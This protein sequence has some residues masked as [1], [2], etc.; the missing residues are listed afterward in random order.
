MNKNSKDIG[1]AI[2]EKTKLAAFYI[3]EQTKC[4][5]T[6]ALWYCA[7]DIASFFERCHI[8][9]K[10]DLD[11]LLSINKND[12]EYKTFLRH[13]SYRLHLYTG[14]QDDCYNW[15][16]TERLLENNDWREAIIFLAGSMKSLRDGESDFSIKSPSV[17]SYYI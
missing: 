15:Y 3:W 14:I 1:D 9:G 4:P 7:E 10:E 6:L 2:A 16:A 12:R 17:K 8:Y 11:G 13:I 5:D